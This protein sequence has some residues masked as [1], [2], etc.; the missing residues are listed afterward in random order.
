M[1][2]RGNVNRVECGVLKEI[3]NEGLG[4]FCDDGFWL[5]GLWEGIGD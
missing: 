4:W 5:I 2:R 1:E 3:G